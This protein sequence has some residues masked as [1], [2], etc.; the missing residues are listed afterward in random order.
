MSNKTWKEIPST[1]RYAEMEKVNKWF[2]TLD[3]PDRP[4][5]FV[6]K[7]LNQTGNTFFH[8]GD[9]H[10]KFKIEGKWHSNIIHHEGEIAFD[11]KKNLA[12]YQKEVTQIISRWK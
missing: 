3:L 10:E 4:W 8:F 1:K 9:L 2:K 7:K 6:V 12:D 11:P 5:S